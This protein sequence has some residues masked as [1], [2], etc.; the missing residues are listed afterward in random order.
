MSRVARFLFL[1]KGNISKE[2]AK[3]IARAECARR[4]LLWQEP[5]WVHRDFGVW[6]VWTHADHRGGNL[7]ITV[8]RGTGAIKAFS[9]PSLR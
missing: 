2:Q 8:H 6:K 1:S 3:E 5:V 4:G 7:I 9:G